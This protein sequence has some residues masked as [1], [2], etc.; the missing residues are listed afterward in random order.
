[1]KMSFG[2]NFLTVLQKGCCVAGG[3]WAAK[4]YGAHHA[5]VHNQK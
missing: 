1:M 5:A 3:A 2:H 4:M